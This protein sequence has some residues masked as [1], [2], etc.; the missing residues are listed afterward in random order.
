LLHFVPF[1]LHSVLTHS[2]GIPISVRKRVWAT[3]EAWQV[4]Y[5]DAAGKRRSESFPTQREAK[6]REAEIKLAIKSGKHTP[7]TADATVR[8]AGET[9]LAHLIAERKERAYTDNIGQHLRDRIFPALGSVKLGKLTVSMVSDFRSRLLQAEALSRGGKPTGETIS[10]RTAGKVLQTLRAL[11]QHAKITGR[12]GTN[13]ADGITITMASRD[14]KPLEI[15]RDLPTADEIRRI[16]A[17]TES[18]GDGTYGRVARPMF[19]VAIFCG[20]RISEIRGLRWCDINLTKGELHVRQRADKRNQIGSLKTARSA[21]T[22]PFGPQVASALREWRIASGGSSD[23]LVFATRNGRPI[24]HTNLHYLV[25]RP[26]LSAAGI[27]TDA[28]AWHGFR[29]FFISWCLGRK[30][31]GGRE[32]PLLTVSRLAGHSSTSITGDVYGHLMPR[33]DDTGELAAAELGLM[34]V[35]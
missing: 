29:H 9:Y 8:S 14:K 1:L 27:T 23:K 16:I 33:T 6:A 17:A 12:V 25:L 5:K 2:E 13:A 28:Y 32:M 7:I 19:M 4:D 26:T 34:Q 18:M 3:G 22:V 11:L 30:A 31:D 24:S 20:L 21:R 35:K 10:R 15:G